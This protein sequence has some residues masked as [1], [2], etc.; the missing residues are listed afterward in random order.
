MQFTD[1]SS[2]AIDS[3]LSQGQEGQ[4][5]HVAYYSQTV[6]RA[7]Q[8]YWIT[9]KELLAVAE[10]VNPYLYGSHFTIHAARQWLLKFQ[11]PEG[12]I[13]RW[14]Q[15]QQGYDFEVNQSPTH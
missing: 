11:N 2:H 14:I 7:E 10:A 13:A 1:A 5:R 3:P 9:R 8:Q 6:Y 12:Q 15:C 4:E